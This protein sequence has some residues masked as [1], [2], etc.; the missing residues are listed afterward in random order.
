MVHP[1]PFS[2]SPTQG[3]NSIQQPL[4]S[5][6][7]HGRVPFHIPDDLVDQRRQQSGGILVNHEAHGPRKLK[8]SMQGS[9]KP[10]RPQPVSIA[11]TRPSTLSCSGP[12]TFE[13]Q[14][15]LVSRPFGHVFGTVPVEVR[16]HLP[17][18]S[19]CRRAISAADLQHEGWK[20]LPSTPAPAHPPAE[21]L[22]TSL[23]SHVFTRPCPEC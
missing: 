13:D 12:R 20:L 9:R 7:S 16:R 23:S 15:R 4:L 11:L 22:N 10:Q 8:R 6:S 17:W 14:L 2:H 21:R 5:P 3:A 19:P 1:A 18:P